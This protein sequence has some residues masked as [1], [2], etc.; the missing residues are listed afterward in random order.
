MIPC[1]CCP[2]QMMRCFVQSTEPICSDP[3]ALVA[4]PVTSPVP[5]TVLVANPDGRAIANPPLSR[6]ADGNTAGGSYSG[7]STP[8]GSTTGAQNIVIDY[9]YP[10]VQD[11]VTNIRLWNQGGSILSDN[12]GL[13]PLTVVELYDI[14][15]T[16]IFTSNL[17]AGNGGAIFSTVVSAF[18]GLDGVAK[19]RLRNLGKISTS[20]ASPLWRNIDLQLA[21][22]AVMTWDCPPVQVAADVNGALAG[23][24]V[25]VGT[26]TQTNG[27]H[28]LAFSSAEPFTGTIV[29][30]NPGNFSTLAITNGTV[31]T[32]TGNAV[33]QFDVDFT[34]P[35]IVPTQLPAFGMLCDGAVVWYDSQGLQVN[36][37]LLTDCGD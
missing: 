27:P 10:V 18:P 36:P 2:T 17:N 30:N 7:F 32:L 23:L 5:T 22:H 11:R 28:T 14:T 37:V 19:L 21:Y 15:D 13:S 25:G 1:D 20:G 6:T 26:L 3:P 24:A 12:D 34:L 4:D 16:L 9:V 31:V 8:G 33:N 35:S 29:T